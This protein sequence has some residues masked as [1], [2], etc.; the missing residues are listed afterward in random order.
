MGDILWPATTSGLLALIV[1]DGLGALAAYATG[2]AFA[3]SWS[4]MLGLVPAVLALAL[5]IRFLHYA[6]FQEALLSAHYYLIDLVILAAAAA[7]G[8]T[9]T[10][11]RQMS[12]Q[13]SWAYEKNGLGWRAR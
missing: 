2:K 13:Y 4:A 8:Y 9:L 3:E 12:T 11:A 7:Y 1:L 6:L 10:R 5:G